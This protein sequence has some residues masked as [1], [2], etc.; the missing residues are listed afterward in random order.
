MISL[1]DNRKAAVLS[2]LLVWLSVLPVSAESYD[3]TGSTT[4]QEV[5]LRLGAS[6]TKKWHNGLRLSISEDLRFGMYGHLSGTDAK[7]TAVDTTYSPMF[8]KSYTSIS[9]GY[10]PIPYFKVDAG[11]TLRILGRKN[12]ENTAKFLRHRVFMS[13]TGA[14][15]NEYLKLYVRERALL[16]MR[17]DSV[18]PLE[19]NRFN[20]LLRSRVGA[21]F[22]VLGKPVKPY[23]WVELE[24]TLN[25]PEYQQRDGKQF[26][27]H[28]RTQAGVHWRITRLSALDFY[29]RFTYGYDRD[30]N[31]TKKK[32]LV[33]LTEETLFQHAV[34][35]TY[36]LDW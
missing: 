7:A 5:Q 15:K 30:V 12:L 33:E 25:A 6:F 21:D 32:S 20:W 4:E 14:Y 10:A 18:N 19:K 13:V 8:D 36:N 23:L 35:V 24:N 34:G 22:T 11:Y 31:V 17:T 28:V 1:F 26:I 9:L 2:A 29:Y 3:A 16:E 27:S